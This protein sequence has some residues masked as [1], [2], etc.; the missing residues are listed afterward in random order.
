MTLQPI[1]SAERHCFGGPEAYMIALRTQS[2]N[3]LH[4]IG[5]AV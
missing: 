1:R 5:T 2:G 3:D 4:A